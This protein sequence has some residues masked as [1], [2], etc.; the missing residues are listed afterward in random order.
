MIAKNKIF[1]SLIIPI[2][3][4]FFL[5]SSEDIIEAVKA[6]DLQKVEQI[7][8][9]NPD[10]LKITTPDKN[11]LLT[12]AASAGS[13]D[14]VTFL[15]S[16]GIPI[17]QQNKNGL[18]AL[19]YAVF[20]GHNQVISVLLNHGADI[21]RTENSGMTSLHIAVL[22]GRETTA[23]LLLKK[24]AKIGVKNR[25]GWTPLMLGTANG[26]T[27]IVA[28][29]IAKGA[30]ANVKD[31]QG[32][33]PLQVA[34]KRGS[35]DLVKLLVSKGAD[36]NIR[37]SHYQRS[38]LHQAAV[39]GY[40]KVAEVL[41]E[42][43]MD[44]NLKDGPGNPPLYYAQKYGQKR[45]TDL[46]LARGAKPLKIGKMDGT[47]SMLKRKL[48]RGEAFIWYLGHSGWA[49]KTQNHFLVFDYWKRRAAHEDAGLVNGYIIPQ[50]IKDQ[51]VFVFVTHA[52]GDHYDRQILEWEKQIPQITYIWGWPENPG[53][54][55]ISM[56]QKREKRDVSGMTIHTIFHS[57]DGIPESAFLIQLDGLVIFHSGDHGSGPPPL[58]KEYTDNIDYLAGIAKKFDIIFLPIWGEEFYPIRKLKPRVMFPMHEGGAEYRYAEWAKGAINK[59]P[60]THITVAEIPGD[61][62]FYNDGKIG[63]F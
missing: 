43:G 7:L 16:K 45:V 42:N 15:I 36:S 62:F 10:L 59:Y 19:H 27:G 6:G 21:N 30:D 20:L 12:V 38:L 48:E 53:K 47:R 61:H 44:I 22:T 39:N 5:F 55:Q 4:S 1:I 51:N 32:Q 52:H 56:E 3:F 26:R 25:R 50:E 8:A 54:K 23:S 2:V 33:S 46:L 17:G 18:T 13:A 31:R 14:M 60:Q 29:L 63:K 37:D 41:L 34:V 11:S 9:K 58:K 28:Q 40:A 24:G 57:F 49:V 35:Q